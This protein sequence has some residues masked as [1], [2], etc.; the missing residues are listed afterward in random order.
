MLI[1]WGSWGDAVAACEQVAEALLPMMAAEADTGLQTKGSKRP[2]KAAEVRGALMRSVS[3]DLIRPIAQGNFGRDRVS[4]PCRGEG[5]RRGE[6]GWGENARLRLRGSRDSKSRRAAA[7]QGL[8]P[9]C[10]LAA[11]RTHGPL[12]AGLAAGLGSADRY[13][14]V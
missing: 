7:R 11:L 5:A 9:L 12:A 4:T 6:G 13:V 14:Q 1:Y 10:N 2:R 3:P 8:L